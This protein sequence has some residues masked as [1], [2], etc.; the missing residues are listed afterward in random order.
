ME[1]LRHD[2]IEL[3]NVNER[4]ESDYCGPSVGERDKPRKA[5][6]LRFSKHMPGLGL[7][8]R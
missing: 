3:I 7:A 1:R 5:L 8:H 6:T 2:G 4:G